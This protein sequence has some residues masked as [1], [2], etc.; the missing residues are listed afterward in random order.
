MALLIEIESIDSMVVLPIVIKICLYLDLKIRCA[1]QPC[2]QLARV[3]QGNMH[4]RMRAM[5]A[6]REYL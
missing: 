3:L 2:T 4:G 5:G 6:M 1:R